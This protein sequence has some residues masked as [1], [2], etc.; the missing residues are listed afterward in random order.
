MK[1]LVELEKDLRPSKDEI[2]LIRQETSQIIKKLNA[3]LRLAKAILGGS[4]AK[5]TWIKNVV[6]VDIFVAY[7]YKKFSNRSAELSDLLHPVL[8]K[9]FGKVKRIHGSRDYFQ[10][11]RGNLI[12]EIVPILAVRRSIDAKNITDVSPLHASWI[13]KRIGNM[14]GDVRLLKAFCKAQGI[15]G[16]ESHIKGLSGYVCEILVIKYGGFVKV[17]RAAQK[18]QEPV[19]IDVGRHY[20]NKTAVLRELNRSK[21][22]PLIII[23]PV[24]KDRNAAAAI[25]EQSIKEF[26]TAAKKFLMRPSRAFFV[27]KIPTRDE[28]KKKASIVIEV[29][30]LAGKEDIVASKVLKAR[31]HLQAEL[32]KHGFKILS[33]EWYWSRERTF[34]WFILKKTLLDKKNKVSGP[35]IKNVFHAER[36]KKAHKNAYTEKGRLYAIVKRP[37]VDAILCVRHLLKDAYVKSRVKSAEVI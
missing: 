16:A 27:R 30:P 15:Y 33:A 12:F 24:Q 21:L 36:F 32:Q 34:L 8:K 9:A 26:K 4:G 31:G 3:R 1:F 10:I 6:D 28:I 19:F 22:S 13:K 20:Y 14:R 35:P 23:D 17:L 2:K 25:N 5:Q 7:N 18:W 29:K 11:Y 37:Y